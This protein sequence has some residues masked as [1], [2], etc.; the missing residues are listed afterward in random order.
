MTRIPPADPDTYTDATRAFLQAREDVLGFVPNSM[1]VM[2]RRPSVGAA[3]VALSDA[4]ISGPDM[5]TPVILRRMV[6][7]I[8]SYAAGCLYCQ[9]HTANIVNNL[10]EDEQKMSNIWEFETN[11]MFSEPERIALRFAMQAAS[12]PNLVTDETIGEMRGH[13][14]DDEITELLA[15]VSVMGFMNRWNDTLATTLEEAPREA[16]EKTIGQKG[17]QVGQHG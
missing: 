11:A 16:A 4:V 14:S 1:K 3:F 9:A 13:F 7:H 6:Q 15:C 17:W 5:T 2:A 10:S 12:V 8:A